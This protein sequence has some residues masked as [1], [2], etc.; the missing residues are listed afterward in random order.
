[1]IARQLSALVLSLLLM[2][3]GE[4]ACAAVGA[5]D[6][7]DLSGE[8]PRIP[9]TEPD[10]ALATFQTLPG[11]RL[12][13]VAAEPLVRDP[14]ALSF[15]ER[16]RLYVVE[17]CDYSEQDKDFLGV[18][19]RLEDTDNDG[20]FDKS[21][22]FADK[23]SWPTAVICYG[24]GV[25]VGAAPDI[26]FLK[27][28]DGDGQADERRRV[29]TGFERSNVQGLLNSFNW[30]LD[31]R[32]HGATSSSGGSVRPLAGQGDSARPVPL[33]GRD[34]AFDPRTFA[35]EATSGGAQHGLSFDDWG[36]KF[37]CSNSDHIQLVMFEDRYAARNPH[38]SAPG[39]RL[40]IAADGP[41]A[42][43][44]RI[45]PVEPWRIVRTRLR[46]AGAVPGPVEGGG[47]AA[48][49][50]TSATGV[51]IY[52]GDALPAP[53]H[54]NA[55]IGDVGSNVVH[56]K[57]IEPRGVE[58]V[59]RRVDENRELLA[60]TDIWFRPAQFA[61]APD[62][63]L[64]I[65]DVYREVIEHP[66]SL[67]PVIKQHLDLTSGRD[68]GRIYRLVPEGF[69][70]PPA[71]RLDEKGTAELVALLESANG[72]QRDTV[73]RL[74]HERQ[75]AAAAGPLAKLANESKSPL[76]RM[77]ALYAL[78]GLKAL[79]PET[80][81]ARLADEHPRVREHAV[82]LSEPLLKGTAGKGAAALRTKLVAL[83]D[84][85]DARVRYQLAFTAGELPIAERNAALARIATR[86]ADDRWARFAIL[87][88]VED[89]AGPFFATL[90]RD[91]RFRRAP[92]SQTLL[93]ELA[94]LI[95][96]S[97]S[98]QATEPALRAIDELSATDERAAIGCLLA[99]ARA[100]SIDA[101][102]QRIGELKLS[103]LNDRL[104]RAVERA[105]VDLRNQELGV[106]ERAGALDALE[107]ADAATRLDAAVALLSPREPQEL[108]LAALQALAGATGAEV[109]DAIIEG[110]PQLA[111]TVRTAAVELLFARANR[112]PK[113]LDAVE[114]ERIRPADIEPA[115][116]ALLLKNGDAG[117]RSRAEKLFAASRS[118]AR[119]EIVERYRPALKL[120]GDA[121]AGREVFRKN[122]AACHKLEGAGHEIGPNLATIKNRG[123]E[124]IL[125]NVLDPNREVNPQY[126]NYLLVTDDGRSVTG[127]IKSESAAS[128]TL[129]RGDE[130]SDTV[131][132]SEVEALQSTGLSLMPEGLEQQID[133][134]ALANLIAYLLS[135][136]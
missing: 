5:G 87:T 1:M 77:H 33:R 38:V 75:D 85:D 66:A 115:R 46:V 58:L 36:R 56:R 125:T 89:D 37:V 108:Q 120:A 78:A 44:Y 20:R 80:L 97:G 31:N 12:E 51:T 70:Q 93:V 135:I 21:I 32:I 3:T 47:R 124:A 98:P 96:R 43:V 24:G 39:A 25:F 45:S 17:M 10:R 109:A 59:A 63:A 90:A 127:M 22:V 7:T 30:G 92:G 123:A 91:G 74:I 67:P 60:S 64:Y 54:G 86:D 104:E 27:D 116:Q 133:P 119:A 50:F 16:G 28:T 111:P 107:L 114:Q 23:F 84:D 35:I 11:L 15:D 131:L 101:V 71:A 53:F 126:L 4:P 113:V 41:Q 13:L 134:P 14:V 73:A 105:Q 61:N 40:S 130:Q 106:A 117:L 99:L 65:A 69:R 26:W 42:E 81:L 19:R 6:S 118:Q 76:A 49:Y 94:D 48:G 128:I 121:A 62:G 68:R 34:F 55:I 110:W 2:M 8:L 132:R 83:A 112:L 57:A 122:C 79:A 103:D 18:I 129:V 95:A 88:S 82:R 9:A 102:R 29:L 52:R 136:K 100:S 72:W